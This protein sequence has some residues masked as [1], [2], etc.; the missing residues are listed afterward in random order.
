VSESA[1]ATRRGS[2]RV[3]TEHGINASV[4]GSSRRS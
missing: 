2:T 1:S 4:T 3:A